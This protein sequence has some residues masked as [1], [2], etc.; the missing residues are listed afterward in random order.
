MSSRS[1]KDLCSHSFYVYPVSTLLT[2]QLQP[3]NVRYEFHMAMNPKMP[4]VWP[5][6]AIHF[7]VTEEGISHNQ[8]GHLRPLGIHRRR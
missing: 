4:A 3:G 5:V 6:T 7:Y 2:L 1:M 8:V